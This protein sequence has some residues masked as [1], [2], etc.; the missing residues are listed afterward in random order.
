MVAYASSLDCPS[1]MATSVE[2]VEEVFNVLA[3]P[4]VHDQ[5]TVQWHTEHKSSLSEAGQGRRV[6]IGIPREYLT[7]D[8]G[9]QVADLWESAIHMLGSSSDAVADV[10]P[11]DLPHTKYALPTYYVIA[12]AEASSNLAKYD[13]LKYGHRSSTSDD[14]VT[15][16]RTEA[17]GQEV[18]NR[19]LMGTFSLSEKYV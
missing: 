15:A 3:E 4:D 5:R 17:F 2:D 6:T 11:V 7:S 16:S 13:G 9:G 14:A 10:V 8:L 19:I 12:L 18:Q 1:V